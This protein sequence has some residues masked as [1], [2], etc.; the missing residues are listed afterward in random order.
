MTFLTF[1]IFSI[2]FDPIFF[3][4]LVGETYFSFRS[5]TSRRPNI[6]YKHYLNQ[7]SDR[8]RKYFVAGRCFRNRSSMG[9]SNI[10]STSITYD[11]AK[12]H[13]RRVRAAIIQNNWRISSSTPRSLDQHTF[14]FGLKVL[15]VETLCINIIW[16]KYLTANESMLFEKIFFRHRQKFL[17]KI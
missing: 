8:E 11:V 3:P 13:C 12:V 16:I 1:S 15:G 17:K 2:F 5:E 7:I 6:M 4:A 10:L 14:P 9:E